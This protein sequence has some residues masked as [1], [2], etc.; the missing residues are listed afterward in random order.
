MNII[1]GEIEVRVSQWEAEVKIHRQSKRKERRQ[2][3]HP[4][5]K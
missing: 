1:K 2:K 3:C 4:M 5:M